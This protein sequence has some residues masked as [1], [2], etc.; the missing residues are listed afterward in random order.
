[1]ADTIFG[2]IIRKEL[3]ASI[4]YEDD[5]VLAFHD[6]APQAPVHILIVP[7]QSIATLND[8]TEADAALVGHMFLVAQK[9]AREQGFAQAGYRTV[10]NCN[11]DGGQ[12]VFHLHMH[13]LAG[14][15]MD[16]PPG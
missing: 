11:R 2:K 1:M 12:V 5:K 6:I 15:E 10:I 13:L 8:L 3:P 7:K 14:R 16:W 4:V 9:I